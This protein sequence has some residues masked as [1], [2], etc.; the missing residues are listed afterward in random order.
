MTARFGCIRP[1]VATR[2]N[3]SVEYRA[4]VQPRD[5]A[6]RVR[7]AQHRLASEANIWIATASSS[8]EPHLVALSL[9]WDG[10]SIM[11]TTPAANPVASNIAATGRAR[12]SLPDADDV[13][14]MKVAASVTP[15]ADL[16]THQLGELVAALGW[17]PMDE[18]GEWVLLTLTPELIWSWNGLHEDSGRTIMRNGNWLS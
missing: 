3:V 6:V 17:D 7:D 14:T 1:D 16:T 13:V 8:G 9:W 2:A 15:L 5:T 11:A 10:S 4:L 12:A 18:S